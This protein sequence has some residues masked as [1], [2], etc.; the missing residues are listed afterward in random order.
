MHL[1][2]LRNAMGDAGFNQTT[3]AREIGVSQGAIQQILSG[4][5][6]RSRHG[7]DIARVLGVSLEWLL[8]RTS[9]R[10]PLGGDVTLSRET[11]AE[12]L[13]LSLIPELRLGYSM[14]GGSVLDDYERVGYRAFDRDWLRTVARGSGDRLF[15]AQGAGD[16]ME[17]T[18]KDGDTVLIDTAQNDITSQDRIWALSY[19]D[20]GMIK[21]VRRL[22]GGIYHLLSDNPAIGPL[23]A[24]DG[25]MHVVGRVIWIGRKI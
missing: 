8:G 15:V 3:L 18:L 11:I 14:G 24:A 13:N 2:R 21:R 4:D 12:K 6:K 10:D 7:P 1:E 5:T 17:P 23:V 25:E 19:G 20:L 22:P 9:S 16:S